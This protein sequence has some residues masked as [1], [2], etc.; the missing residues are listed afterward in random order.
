MSPSSINS[1]DFLLKFKNSLDSFQGFVTLYPKYKFKNLAGKMSNDFLKRNCFSQG[2]FCATDNEIFE[3]KSVLLEG[4]R[5]IC[6]WNIA[7]QK[8]NGAQIWWEYINHYRDCLNNKMKHAVP[9]GQHCF[10]II[11][12]QMDLSEDTKT[13]IQQCVE[14][15]WALPDDKFASQNMILQSNINSQEYKDVYLVPA[16]FINNVLV[17]EDLKSKVVISAI[18][19]KLITKPAICSTYLTSDINWDYQKKISTD[20]NLAFFIVLFA[21]AA[22]ILF[23]ILALL[24]G[25]MGGRI[26]NEINNEVRSHV[27][28]YMRLR[29]STMG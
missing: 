23:I 4:I 7:S 24:K 29:D 6:I 19:E 12:A 2:L 21:F 27:T 9:S 14:H 15:S 17:K 10:D 8:N 26:N 1:Y 13:E 28:E 22:L 16:V 3:P 18:C 25:T 5:Q 20:T 11:S